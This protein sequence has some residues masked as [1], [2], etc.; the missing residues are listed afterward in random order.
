MEAP[1]WSWWLVT[2]VFGPPGQIRSKL[3]VVRRQRSGH[4]P[5]KKGLLYDTETTHQVAEENFLLLLSWW[6]FPFG[7]QSGPSYLGD[8]DEEKGLMHEGRLGLGTLVCSL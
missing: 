1:R 4:Y 8:R 3:D 5:H 7:G 6:G 2:L